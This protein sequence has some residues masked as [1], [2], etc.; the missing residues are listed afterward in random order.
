[1]EILKGIGVSPGMIIGRAFVLD[2]QIR[3]VPKRLVAPEDVE[4]QQERVRRAVEAAIADLEDLRARVVAEVDA[5]AAKILEFHIFLLSD[6]S[7]VNPIL[8]RV[9]TERVTAEYAVSVEVRAMVDK[10]LAMDQEAFRAKVSDLWD[11]DRSLLTH[12]IGERKDLLRHLRDEVVVVAYDLTPSQTLK[13]DTAHVRAFA[14]DAGG[15]ASHTSIM[16][17]ALGI[18]AAVG[19]GHAMRDV[20]D[21]D[22]VIVDGDRGL[23]IIDPDEATIEE[24][25]RRI[26]EREAYELSLQDLADLATETTDGTR[27]SLLAN[28]EFPSEIEFVQRV[29]GDGVGLYRSE[30]LYLAADREPSEEEQ[31]EAYAEAVRLSRGKPL[32][33][34]TLDLGSDKYTQ[35]RAVIPERNPALGCRSIRYCL[36]HLGLFKRQLRAVLRASSE[37]PLRIMFPL[38]TGPMELRQARMVLRD[39]M[40]DLED[41]GVA[42]DPEI[43][44]GMMIE[45]PSAAIMSHVFAREVDFFSIGTNDLIQY[46]LAVDRTNERVANL[47]TSAHPALL[48]MIRAVV[49]SGR[50]AGTEVSL[51]GE[52]ASE[53]V[54]TMLLVGLG[55]RSLSLVPTAIP[56]VK[57]V[58][59]AVDIGRCEALARRVGS[60]DTERQLLNCLQDELR[61][62]V[63]EGIDGRPVD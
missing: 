23:L 59:R 21:G 45:T 51:C 19:L 33:I 1:M 63:P 20:S 12:L 38:I 18:P 34:R 2:E 44:I 10:F 54:Y 61:T 53:P 55:L 14:T 22:D 3:H 49:R 31:Y 40:E 56:D 9:R 41:E 25:R 27:V 5:E 32:V 15:R 50:R 6:P 17:R 35:S 43:P 62:I 52:M 30:F 28:I 11:L 46:T 58:I 37:G 36:Q 13:F 4:S 47:Y 7:F 39:V 26:R 60:F 29:G 16:A 8:E 42:F 48:R 57:R 24:Y